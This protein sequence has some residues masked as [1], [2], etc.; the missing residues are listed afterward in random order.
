MNRYRL[1]LAVSILVLIGVA[2]F[3]FGRGTDRCGAAHRSCRQ[4]CESMPD[5]AACRR[6]CDRALR[7]CRGF[8]QVADRPVQIACSEGP[9]GSAP[10][11]KSLDEVCAILGSCADCAR[12][13]CGD[14][15]WSFVAD[16]PVAATLLANERVVASSTGRGNTATL[17]IPES[18]H[19]GK[20][21][22]LSLRLETKSATVT[23]R[24]DG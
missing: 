12:T 7:E 14:S 21:E 17:V 19:L 20:E 22:Q 10:C 5:P 18:L 15:R 24:R 2:V 16:T 23:I 3:V 8:V 4:G 13:L 9:H 11:L 6:D 1:L